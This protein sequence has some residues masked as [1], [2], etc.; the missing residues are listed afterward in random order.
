METATEIL[1]GSLRKILH[2]RKV[3][4]IPN[5]TFWK[6]SLLLD[7]CFAFFSLCLFIAETSAVLKNAK[8]YQ[9]FMHDW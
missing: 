2:L 4:L 9:G 7:V 3:F 1:F 8:C 6:N 5:I